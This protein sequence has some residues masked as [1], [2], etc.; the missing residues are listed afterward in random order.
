MA[1][2]LLQH[3]RTP[4]LVLAGIVLIGSGL[5]SLLLGADSTE[6][7]LGVGGGIVTA[8]IVAGTYFVGRQFGHPHSH[9]V[10]EAAVAFGGL[11]LIGVS[12]Q[13]LYSHGPE[14]DPSVFGVVSILGAA[15]ALGVVIVGL[16]VALERVGPSPA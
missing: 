11:F 5:A 16:I 7:A 4:A 6:L 14:A 9:A 2:N 13:L 3:N 12:F 1:T 8:G 10:A 15:V